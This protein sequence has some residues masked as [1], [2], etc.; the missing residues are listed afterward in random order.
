[1]LPHVY[2]YIDT[3]TGFGKGYAFMNMK[4]PKAVY[5]LYEKLN[6]RAWASHLSKKTCKVSYARVQ[7]GTIEYD[8]IQK[9][10]CFFKTC[11]SQ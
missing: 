6:G 1:M 11:G 5:L 4:S 10:A 8:F 3:E 2:I 9:S 7:K